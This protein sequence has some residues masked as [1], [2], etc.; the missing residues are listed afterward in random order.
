MDSQNK[1]LQRRAERWTPVVIITGLS[2]VNY[3]ID[4]KEINYVMETFFIQLRRRGIKREVALRK[5]L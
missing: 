1:K 2:L 3:L 4:S 5:M